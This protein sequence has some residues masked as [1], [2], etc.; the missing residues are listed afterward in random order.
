MG[1]LRTALARKRGDGERD[2]M[3]VI[4]S[5]GARAKQLCLILLQI[6]IALEGGGRGG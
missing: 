6:H 4:L 5:G 1:G 3:L 2:M